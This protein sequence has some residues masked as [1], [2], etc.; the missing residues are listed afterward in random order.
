MSIETVKKYY[1]EFNKKNIAGI[2][3]LCTDNVINDLNQGD[4]QEGIAKLKDYLLT[5][6]SHFDEKVSHL[7]IMTNQDQSNIATEYLVN[8]KYY[9]TKEGLFPSTNQVY[10]IKCTSLFK[11]DDSGKISRITRY[12]NAK[13]WIDMVKNN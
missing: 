2:L 4:S 8:G 3:E 11:F 9:N 10:E 13:Q 12:Y 1:L 6:W 7:D 5:A